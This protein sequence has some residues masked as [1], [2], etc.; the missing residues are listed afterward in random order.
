MTAVARRPAA[1]AALAHRPSAR[2]VEHWHRT[3]PIRREW[4]DAGLATEPADRT[5]AESSITRIYA[6]H[7]RPRPTFRWVDSPRQALP[8]L[9]GLPTHETL[10][11]WVSARSPKGTPPIA[12]DI[13]AGLSRLRTALDD[14]ADHPDL[15]APPRRAGAGQKPWPVLPPVD[16]LN[17]GVPLREVLRQGVRGGLSTSLAEA[18]AWPIRQSLAPP[19]TLP[20]CW[21]G[22]QDAPWIAYYD[23]LRR[24]GL[25]HFRLADEDALEDW[26]LLARSCGW[27]W[28]GE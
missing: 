4:L 22:Q 27:W 6:R 12:S 14:A 25:G 1:P 7:A 5:A 20:V 10:H 3:V 8:H 9:N 17:A 18:L 21:Y 28:P 15:S 24:L 26:V 13:A 16:A 2:I 19:R 23:V 11:S